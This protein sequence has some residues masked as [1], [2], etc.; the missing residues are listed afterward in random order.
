MS[1]HASGRTKRDWLAFDGADF[2]A[3]KI[4]LGIVVIGSI[5]FGLGGVL[6]QFALGIADN[7]IQTTGRLPDG[8]GPTFLFEF[9]PLPLAVMIVIALVGEAF[10]RGVVLRDDVEGLV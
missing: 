10:R 7:A 3:L 6:V 1:N 4:V 9:T 5:L 2:L 8:G